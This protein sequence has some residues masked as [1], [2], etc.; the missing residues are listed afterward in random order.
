MGIST[1][2]ETD[3]PRSGPHR[4]LPARIATAGRDGLPHVC[5][6]GWR[7][8]P[9][10]IGIGGH[11]MAQSKEWRD[12]GRTH[13]AAVGAA[14]HRGPGPRRSGRRARAAHPHPPRTGD[15]VGHRRSA[16]LARDRVAPEVPDRPGSAQAGGSS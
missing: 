11:G 1:A 3:Y 12:V 8:D 7:L 13:R 9:E 5:P 15:V 6:V 14:R 2:A 4:E 16:R 10:V